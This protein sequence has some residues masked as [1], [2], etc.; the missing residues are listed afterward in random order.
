MRWVADEPLPGLVEAQLTDSDGRL[1]NFIDKEP[2]F[3]REP[4]GKSTRF[5]ISGAIRCQIIG[6]VIRADG[7]DVITIDTGSPDGVSSEGNTIFRVP[8]SVV[9]GC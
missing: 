6:P 4:L 7:L 5:P 9:S 2:I 3:C 1:W 8:A